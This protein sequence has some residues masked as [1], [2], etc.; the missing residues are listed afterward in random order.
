MSSAVLDEIHSIR[1]SLYEVIARLDRLEES[2]APPPPTPAT[3]TYNRTHAIVNGKYFLVFSARP[4]AQPGVY[5]T[6]RAYAAAVELEEG[7]YHSR[8]GEIIVLHPDA[9]VDDEGCNTVREA[10]D[11]FRQKQNSE[12][13]HHW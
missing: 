7:S 13:L 1:Q 11:R 3:S 10:D 5:K 6:K 4:G 9:L 12:P 2:L 8:P